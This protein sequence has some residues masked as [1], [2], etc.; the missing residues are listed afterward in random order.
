MEIEEKRA[1]NSG[2]GRSTPPRDGVA[3]AIRAWLDSRGFAPAADKGAT[4]AVIVARHPYH[5]AWHIAVAESG[6]ADVAAAFYAAAAALP[7]EGEE[8]RAGIAIGGAAAQAVAAIRGAL[9]A[10]GIA[11]LRVKPSGEVE[12]TEPL[13]GGA[14]SDGLR[15][16]EL[17]ASNDD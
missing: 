1:E 14:T 16:E 8:A 2:E 4:A 6:E 17:D 13:P 9:D 3:A 12:L 15:P 11:V 7:A 10:L 5:P